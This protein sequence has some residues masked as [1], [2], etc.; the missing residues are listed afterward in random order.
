MILNTSD[1]KNI[2][3][4]TNKVDFRKQI[5]GLVAFISHHFDV[6][7][8]DRPLFIFI[9]RNKSKLKIMEEF[10]KFILS[11]STLTE[12]EIRGLCLIHFDQSNDLSLFS[13][14]I[15]NYNVSLETIKKLITW[16]EESNIYFE[17]DCT[18]VPIDTICILLER[19]IQNHKIPLKRINNYI[20]FFYL[21]NPNAISKRFNYLSNHN[22][23]INIHNNTDYSYNCDQQ[24]FEHI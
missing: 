10:Y 18:L 15:K 20:N 7:I 6:D 8:L 2:Y 12:N 13:K 11:K 9:N 23:T 21:T 1:V 17:N 5:D 14:I 3:L 16:L 22:C 24:I 4:C 19:D